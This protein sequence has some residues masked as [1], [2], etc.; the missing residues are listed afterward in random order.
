MLLAETAKPTDQW[1]LDPD[2]TQ[3]LRLAKAA[4]AASPG[5]QAS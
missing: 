5:A 2:S 3:H 1:R 4:V